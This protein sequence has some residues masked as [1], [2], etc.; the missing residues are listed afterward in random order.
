MKVAIIGTGFIA[1]NFLSQCSKYSDVDITGIL[2]RR[3][4]KT[5]TDFPYKDKLTNWFDPLI[6]YDILF[7]CSGSTRWANRVLKYFT[8][9]QP[10]K[11]V[12][13]MNSEFHVTYGSN[14]I[15][16]KVTESRGDQPGAFV[17]LDNE[18]KDMGF[19]P[20]AYL[21]IKRFLDHRPTM[22]KVMYWAN[23]YGV[24]PNIIMASL[25]GTKIQIE[26]CLVANH[27]GVNI[28]RDGMS[29]KR[30]STIQE[31]KSY[32]QSSPLRYADYVMIDN[33]PKGVAI[34]A[35]HDQDQKQC[36]D[37]FG[38]DDPPYILT[39]PYHLCH[40]EVIKSLR[41]TLHNDEKL[42][43]NSDNPRYNVYAIAKHNI[44]Q[45]TKIERPIGN[46]HFRGI[47]KN[48]THSNELIPI[49]E[50]ENS[51]FVKNVKEFE[52]IKR[53]DIEQNEV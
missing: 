2:T 44:Q 1:K 16:K 15:D 41:E 53:S 34:M 9:M 31:L 32:H 51:T 11:P 14:F 19:S 37:Y 43:T 42:L 7:E 52:F 18:I 26:Q 24:S 6:P 46:I 33:L 23:E 17:I 36:L 4:I 3:D 45:G 38:L 29:G 12:V 10:N 5:I 25:D 48:I 30:F 13:T 50:L 39:K 28:I 49:G 8:T 47:C 35:T 21:N 27:F 20:Y 40:L 22:K